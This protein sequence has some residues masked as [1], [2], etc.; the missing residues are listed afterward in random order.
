MPSGQQRLRCHR[1]QSELPA[2]V[3]S[4]QALSECPS[5]HTTL[6]IVPLPG[7]GRGPRA[8]SAAQP[9]ADG[10]EASC[11]YHADKRAV[12]PC[13]NCGRF[14]CALCDFHI[15]NRHLCTKCIETASKGTHLG[16]LERHRRRWDILQWRLLVLPLLFCLYLVPFCSIAAIVIG[17][18]YRNAPPS[19]VSNNR[20]WLNAGVVFGI[21]Q[22]LGIIAL[23]I[24]VFYGQT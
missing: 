21:V 18:K 20:A 7:W 13:D 4:L 12:L 9:I 19:L 2:E 3:V 17:I 22:F 5:C 10:Q 11:F 6:R 15:G 1:C 14:L 23:A 16:E 24:A 8:G